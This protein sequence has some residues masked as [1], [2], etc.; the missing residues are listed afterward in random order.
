MIPAR[1]AS[2]AGA[3]AGPAAAADLVVRRAD[4][5]DAARVDAFALETLRA[6]FFHRAGWTRAVCEEFGHE[7]RSLVAERDRGRVVGVMPLAL[8]RGLRGGGRSISTPYGVYGGPIGA[9]DEA[10]RASSST[11]RS[12]SAR[13]RRRPPARCGAWRIPSPR[14]PESDLHAT[15]I[16]DLGDDPASV[17]PGMPKKS[18]ADA[19]A[20]RARPT[21]SA[22][23]GAVVPARPR[24][25]LPRNKH[26]LGSPA[27]PANYFQRL[28]DTFG[29]RATIHVVKKDGETLAAVMSFLFRDP[30]ARLSLR[31]GG[32]GRIAPSR[33]ASSCTWPCRSG[34]SRTATGSSTSAAAARTPARSRSRSIR[35][36][37]PGTCTTP[38]AS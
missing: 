22:P 34:P 30:R 6:S 24:P 31:H 28:L 19:R 37:R 21:G 18:R 17:L 32:R 8:C 14:C 4:P 25:P 36:S 35:A 33:P 5:G 1:G 23:R 38:S 7:D 11:R 29:D 27:L 3:R 13:A 12:A 26:A 16:K 10:E 15:F 20:A 9:D 2:D